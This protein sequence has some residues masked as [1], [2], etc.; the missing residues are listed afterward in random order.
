[1]R[2][3]SGAKKIGIKKIWVI[4]YLVIFLIPLLVGVVAGTVLYNGFRGQVKERN[5]IVLD[6]ICTAVD[7]NLEAVVNASIQLYNNEYVNEIDK[8]FSL[9]LSPDNS[10]YIYQFVNNINNI[11]GYD[12]ID[13][14]VNT[15]FIYFSGIDYIVQNSAA[16]PSSEFYN[17]KVNKKYYSPQQWEQFVQKEYNSAFLNTTLLSE[18][19]ELLFVRT[20]RM[21]SDRGTYVNVVYKI[22]TQK[23]LEE[24]K[25][26]YFY[27]YGNLY[28]TDTE[29]NVI[30]TS[31]QNNDAEKNAV[32][33]D[34]MLSFTKTSDVTGWTYTYKI[35]GSI[36]YGNLYKVLIVMAALY[37]L[38]LIIGLGLIRYFIKRN[39]KPINKLM[40]L[41]PEDKEKGKNNEF[42]YLNDKITESISRNFALNQEIDSQSK[43]IREHLINEILLGH[44][45]VGK[46]SRTEVEKLKFDLEKD[47]FS[48][49]IYS[50][51]NKAVDEL[52]MKQFVLCNV[53][54]ELLA[55]KGYKCANVKKDENIIYLICSEN[56]IDTDEIADMVQFLL[57]FTKKEFEFTFFSAMGSIG[58]GM[59]SIADSF[60]SAKRAVEYAL[61][62]GKEEFTL[63]SAVASSLKEGYFYS[64]ELESQLVN[65]IKANEQKKV[66]V[67]LE[68]I[69]S[70]N[71]GDD[72]SLDSVR[73]LTIELFATVKRLMIQYG[74]LPE[75]Q[76]PEE[77]AFI[78]KIFD[79]R[80]IEKMKKTVCN[81]YVRCCEDVFSMPSGKD[82]LIGGVILYINQNYSN[83]NLGIRL[84]GEAFSMNGDYVSRKFR[85]HTGKSINDYIKDVRVEKAKEL[86]RKSDELIADIAEM[87]GFTSYRTFVR[88]FTDVVGVTP[89]KYKIMK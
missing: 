64:I 75:K 59:D 7:N 34:K 89:N 17:A 48:V 84:I 3:F 38:C 79:S 47:Y 42:L 27:E 28:V 82:E 39:Y 61:A 5:S 12:V 24:A 65:L 72:I 74:Y 78:E 18:E 83:Q 31:S 2:N 33:T 10:F 70:R 22:D 53:T 63:Y 43:M 66:I 69:F 71:T 40:T 81:I 30:M 8:N 23:I 6:S 51:E 45:P 35:P 87:V 67:L 68:E 76:Y 46:R 20:L 14:Y 37:G 21:Q 62:A 58:I 13:N 73:Y 16:Q 26:L 50:F 54:D 86:L 80:D 29:G 19:K 9:P 56:E 44:K 1:M 32:A 60:N 11:R 55:D 85:E 49:L 4:S 36:A 57:G 52:S 88:V 41:F 77:T 15:F 25:K